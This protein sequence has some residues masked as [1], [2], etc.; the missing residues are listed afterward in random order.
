MV[1]LCDQGPN[2]SS[3]QVYRADSYIEMVLF[4][5]LGPKPLDRKDHRVGYDGGRTVHGNDAQQMW[6]LRT[7]EAHEDDDDRARAPELLG[8]NA[9]SHGSPKGRRRGRQA[10]A[11]HSGRHAGEPSRK[12]HDCVSARVNLTDPVDP[13]F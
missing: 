11:A 2:S 10:T 3:A 1:F 8:P 7:A 9:S 6:L 4:S 5:S 13:G 12:S